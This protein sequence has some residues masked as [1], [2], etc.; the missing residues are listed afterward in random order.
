MGLKDKPCR[1][2]WKK[3]HS[4]TKI[5]KL[6]LAGTFRKH[7][8]RSWP[9]LV[10]QTESQEQKLVNTEVKEEREKEMEM[11]VYRA[12]WNSSHSFGLTLAPFSGKHLH[13]PLQSLPPQ[14]PLCFFPPCQTQ[15][16]QH[17]GQKWAIRGQGIEV[18]YKKNCNILL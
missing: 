14:G 2:T 17:E 18:K 8:V 3:S 10:F 7:H 6:Q 1:K 11:G 4:A 15:N 13:S 9:Y 12:I 16:K 5:L